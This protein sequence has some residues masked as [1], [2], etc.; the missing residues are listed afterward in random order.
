MSDI[1][2]YPTA[3]YPKDDQPGLSGELI[4][5][6]SLRLT[7]LLTL[8]DV[9]GIDPATVVITGGHV[10]WVRQET[11]TDRDERLARQAAHAQWME[12]SARRQYERLHE[13]FGGTS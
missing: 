5:A 6:H 10:K 8:L 3:P 9:R 7:A 12:D 11:T 4:N 2:V 13:R 1:T